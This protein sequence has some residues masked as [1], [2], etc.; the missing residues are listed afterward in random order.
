MSIRQKLKHELLTVALTTAYFAIW[1]GVLLVLKALLLAE[2]NIKFHRF[3]LAIVGALIVAKVVLVLDH[4][5]LDRLL[6][7]MPGWLDVIV[8]TVLYTL[9]VFAVLLLE[10]AFEG[11][12]E[13]G[14]FG[15]ALGQ[16]FSH[17]DIHH[18]WVTVICLSGA[19]MGFNIFALFRRH[20]GSRELIRMVVAPAPQQLEINASSSKG[21]A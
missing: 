1:F 14:G 2:Y 19:L 4:V 5:P 21:L 11:R 15:R 17:A 9:G 10:K 20:L 13:Y 18:V 6:G 3:T 8:R 12:H 7:R 16:V